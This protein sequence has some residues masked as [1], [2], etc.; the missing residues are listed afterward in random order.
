MQSRNEPS[1]RQTRV[2]HRSAR[3]SCKRSDRRRNYRGV[4]Y[5]SAMWRSGFAAHVTK[6]KAPRSRGTAAGS[7]YE[8][9]GRCKHGLKAQLPAIATLTLVLFVLPKDLKHLD[10]DL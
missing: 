10:L 5:L 1:L 2:R 4:S 7:G 3:R 6:R 9:A 8:N